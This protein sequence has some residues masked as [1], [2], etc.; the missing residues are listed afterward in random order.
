MEQLHRELRGDFLQCDSL[1][2]LEESWAG[3]PCVGLKHEKVC[4]DVKAEQY[5]DQCCHIWEIL[6][7]AENCVNAE[8]GSLRPQVMATG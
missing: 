7:S 8:W 3:R 6:L 4:S 5:S 1:T 2:T